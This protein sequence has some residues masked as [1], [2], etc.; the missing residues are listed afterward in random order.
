MKRLF[1]LALIGL[2]VAAL[3]PSW[4]VVRADDETPKPE[5]QA[6]KTAEE[7]AEGDP[8]E[9][10]KQEGQ[11]GE[12]AEAEAEAEDQ[13]EVEKPKRKRPAGPYE[14]KLVQIETQRT[15]AQELLD[16]MPGVE[17]KVAKQIGK[18]TDGA[19]KPVEVTDMQ[20]DLAN[21][22]MTPASRKY[23]AL[24]IQLA[25]AYDRI[26]KMYLKAWADSVKLGKAR[27]D[28]LDLASQRDEL[29]EGLKK[30]TLS[31]LAKQLTI[32]G[33]ISDE[34]LLEATHKQ[35]LLVDRENA[36]SRQYLTELAK[37]RKSRVKESSGG[38]SSYGGGYGGRDGDDRGQRR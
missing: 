16:K 7:S 26:K 4:S 30:D 8:A 25:G 5:E 3:V 15:K 28:D 36:A 6:E 21:R 19:R 10:A 27:Q 29:E 11:Q 2:L 38:G 34:K 17:T 9:E 37:R 33:N 18:I 13:E 12:E 20:R 31:V 23:R 14:R 1:A 24:S 32:Y 22:S 35:V